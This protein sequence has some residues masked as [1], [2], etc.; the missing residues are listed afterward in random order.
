MPD[1]PIKLTV[2]SVDTGFAEIKADGALVGF[3]TADF[4]WRWT[5]K[6]LTHAGER[7][8]GYADV[9]TA[10]SL[11]ELRA[12]LRERLAEKGPWWVM[13]EREWTT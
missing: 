8:G 4:Y 7:T 1:R 5:A 13:P 11:R 2:P 3:A 6:L 9:V 12:A 10:G